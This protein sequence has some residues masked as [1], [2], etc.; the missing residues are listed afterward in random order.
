MRVHHIA[1]SVKN[2]EKSAQFYKEHFD[3]KE[4]RRFTKPGWDGSAIILQLGDL[5]LELFQFQN[6][7]E[8]QDDLSN[9]KVI[10]LKHIG[11]KVTSVKGIYEK[12]KIAHIDIDEPK[13]GTTCAW[14][15][16][17]RDPDGIPIELYEALSHK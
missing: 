10:G 3:F 6:A 9:L 8:K 13:K 1:L 16:F 7:I 14:Y 17:L 15:C 11:I 5:Q 4:I 12:I 2:S